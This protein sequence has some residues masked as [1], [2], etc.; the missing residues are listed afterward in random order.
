MRYHKCPGCSKVFN[1]EGGLVSVACKFC[2]YRS[3]VPVDTD[4]PVPCSPAVQYATV[5][6]AR[7]R[8]IAAREA[9]RAKITG[10]S[11]TGSTCCRRAL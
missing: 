11:E 1:V 4:T 5:A 6:S 9:Y 10:M 8:P 2:D 7:L 3:T